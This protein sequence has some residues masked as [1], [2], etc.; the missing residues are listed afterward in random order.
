MFGS[1]GVGYLALKQ[2]DDI[3]SY[4]P[5]TS[6]GATAG[7]FVEVGGDFALT[8]QV[9]LV[10]S[11]ADY[12]GSLGSYRLS[13]NGRTQTV[14]LEDGEKEGLDYLSLNVGLRWYFG[15]R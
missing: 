13:T 3:P 10:V 12:S 5:V 8:D 2:V 7:T 6:K 1:F 4:Y 11:L 15:R 14:T 9:F